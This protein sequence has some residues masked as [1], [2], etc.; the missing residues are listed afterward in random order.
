M[1][2]PITVPDSVAVDLAVADSGVAAGVVVVVASEVEASGAV[3]IAV[4]EENLAVFQTITKHPTYSQT[5]AS[6][7]FSTCLQT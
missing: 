5:E 7:K 3:G 6:M 4:S 1:N 2:V